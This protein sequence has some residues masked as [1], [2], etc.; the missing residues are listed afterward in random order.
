MYCT[1]CKK[2]QTSKNKIKFKVLY[3]NE[4]NEKK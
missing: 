2:K 1:N 4:T 3:V